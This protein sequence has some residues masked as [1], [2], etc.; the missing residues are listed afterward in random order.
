MSLPVNSLKVVGMPSTHLCFLLAGW[1]ADVMAGAGAREEALLTLD[2][3][4][5]LFEIEINSYIV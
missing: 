1:D 2:Y 4:W 3:L 5:L